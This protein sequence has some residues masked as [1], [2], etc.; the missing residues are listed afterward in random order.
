VAVRKKH[1]TDY[2]MVLA[3]FSVYAIC[4][5]LLAAIGATVY[6][7]TATVMKHNY[8]ERTSI[9]YVAEKVRQ[10]DAEGAVRIERFA[11]GDALVFIEPVD[12]QEYETWL[13]VQND[14]LYEAFVASPN[15]PDPVFGQP[16]MPMQSML[17]DMD[18][19]SERSF[20]VTFVT[21]DG[22]TT[23]LHLTL[24]SHKAVDVR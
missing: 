4:A 19:L 5:L 6:R 17:I 24:D 21:V 8:D 9:L 16:I 23:S 11:Q 15:E 10:N 1:H 20:A 22:R 7:D 3:L 13:Y 2:F 14:V 12:G 18:G